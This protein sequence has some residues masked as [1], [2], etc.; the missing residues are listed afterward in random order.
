MMSYR[1][2]AIDVLSDEV[3]RSS[4]EIPPRRAGKAGPNPA[5]IWDGKGWSNVVTSTRPPDGDLGA[6]RSDYSHS[7]DRWR[8]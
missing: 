5:T 7:H 2:Q 4:E 8:Y 6:A 3:A 1:L